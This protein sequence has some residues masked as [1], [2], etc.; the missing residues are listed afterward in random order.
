[1]TELETT[2][3]LWWAFGLNNDMRRNGGLKVIIVLDTVIPTIC[4]SICN[5]CELFQGGEGIS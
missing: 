1:M 4:S 2:R 5:G 3:Y